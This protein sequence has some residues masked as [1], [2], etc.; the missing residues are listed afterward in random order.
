MAVLWKISVMI[1]LG[2]P[3][4][5]RNK[6]IPSINAFTSADVAAFAAKYFDTTPS[7]FIVGKDAVFLEP[8][9]KYFPDVEV[10]PTAELDLNRAGLTKAK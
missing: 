1:A 6:F 7:Q 2:L 5:E 3:L 9:K 8:P 10:I 4:D